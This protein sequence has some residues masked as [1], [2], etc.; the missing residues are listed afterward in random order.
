M[1]NA[2]NHKRVMLANL[3]TGQCISHIVFKQGKPLW[4]V[5]EIIRI[6]IEHNYGGLWTSSGPLPKEMLTRKYEVVQG[7]NEQSHP[8][9]IS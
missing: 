2:I 4:V 1:S 3:N 7:C 9:E 6:E 8:K 5:A